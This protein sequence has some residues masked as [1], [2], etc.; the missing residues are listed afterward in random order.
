MSINKLQKIRAVIVTLSLI[1]FP[2]TFYY[3]SPYISIRAGTAGIIS[4]SVIVFLS[5]LVAGIFFGRSFCSWICPAGRIQDQVGIAR[6]KAVNVKRISWLKYIVWGA[7]LG[8]LLFFLR[9]AGGIKGIEFAFDTTAGFSTTSIY[10]LI[11]YS[12]VVLVFFS[13]ALVFGKRAGCHT[14]CW[15]A[16]FMVIGRKIGLAL[17]LPSLHLS[18]EPDSCVSCGR[19]TKTCPMSL[20]V[21]ELV[22]KGR[23]TDDSCILCG[24]CI[25]TCKKDTIRWAWVG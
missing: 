2:V 20:P 18:T 16:P 19:C 14:I 11:A 8:M 25:E 3:F 24:N 15:I 6:P 10:A 5:L 7:W 13:L 9:R 21:D 1:L 22:G 12:I 23:I 17:R 4:G